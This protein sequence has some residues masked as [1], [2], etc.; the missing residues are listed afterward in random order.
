[1]STGIWI[2]NNS[3]MNQTFYHYNNYYLDTFLNKYNI[4]ILH[5]VSIK[6][7]LIFEASLTQK[8]SVTDSDKLRK[9]KL[10]KYNT[11]RSFSTLTCNVVTQN[12]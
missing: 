7:F 9:K 4:S 12:A 5:S 2:P 10:I 1:M 3:I 8:T 6:C 11:P